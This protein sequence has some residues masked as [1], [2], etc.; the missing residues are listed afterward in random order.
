M[1]ERLKERL[2]ARALDEGFDACRVCRPWDVPE[3][4]ERLAA[5]LEKGYHGQMSWSPRRSH[6]RARR[7]FCGQKAASVIV[8]GEMKE[9]GAESESL[10]RAVGRKAAVLD[11]VL[12]VTMGDH[13]KPSAGGSGSRPPRRENPPGGH[14]PGS[15]PGGAGPLA[16]GP[17]DPGERLPGHDHG[18]GDRKQT[19]I[20]FEINFFL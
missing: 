4:P 5:F 7:S 9:L 3:V 16:A 12:L 14:P 1:K 10:H 20:F 2:V 8:L 15:R 6:W 18:E 13:A 17:M 11:P 19:T